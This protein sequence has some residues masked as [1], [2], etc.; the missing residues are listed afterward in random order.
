MVSVTLPA[1]LMTKTDLLHPHSLSVGMKGRRHIA[2]GASLM[3]VHVRTQSPFFKSYL[4]YCCYWM[5]ERFSLSSISLFLG[6]IGI[7]IP[8]AA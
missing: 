5:A 3:K 2:L 7:I 6:G 8:Q 1:G 4:A